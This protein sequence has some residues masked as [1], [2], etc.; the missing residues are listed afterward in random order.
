MGLVDRVIEVRPGVWQAQR[1]KA[2]L[3]RWHNSGPEFN[4]PPVIEADGTILKKE[5]QYDRTRRR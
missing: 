2:L 4:A 1:K 5:K 3:G